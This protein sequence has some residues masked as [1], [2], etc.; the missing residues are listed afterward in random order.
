MQQ[1][2]ESVRSEVVG[3]FCPRRT[4]CYVGASKY[5]K[6]S[7]DGRRHAL[8]LHGHHGILL[9][10]P[11]FSIFW[12]FAQWRKIVENCWFVY[13]VFFFFFFSRRWQRDG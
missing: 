4:I 8:Q 2:K 7:D 12:C 6:S 1:Y 11:V 3:Q 5:V 13:R 9:R 10:G